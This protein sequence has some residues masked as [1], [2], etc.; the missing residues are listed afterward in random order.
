MGGSSPHVRGTFV[1]IDF[2]EIIRRFIPAR[3]GNIVPRIVFIEYPR[4][5]PARAGNI[6][7]DNLYPSNRFIPARAGNIYKAR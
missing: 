3:A 1:R 6:L 5:I 2:F 7:T 4:F